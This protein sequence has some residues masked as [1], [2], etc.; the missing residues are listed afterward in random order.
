MEGRYRCQALPRG[1][2]LRRRDRYGIDSLVADRNSDSDHYPLGPSGSL[3]GPRRRAVCQPRRGKKIP[4]VTTAGR[5]SPTH[6]RSRAVP[7]PVVRT[8]AC[9]PYRMR[10]RLCARV[11]PPLSDNARG[12]FALPS[13]ACRLL[14]LLGKR[15]VAA[16]YVE[17]SA[18]GRRIQP[19][20]ELLAHGPAPADHEALISFSVGESLSASLMRR[21]P[22]CQCRTHLPSLSALASCTAA[23]GRRP[24]EPSARSVFLYYVWR[25]LR[26]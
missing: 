22:H 8:D 11:P 24:Q 2:I 12:S 19:F 1:A 6:P 5:V 4:R 15:A 25:T 13:A 20:Q 10:L 3:D 7:A 26:P 21:A 18:I 9:F 14:K 17:P 23:A 16:P